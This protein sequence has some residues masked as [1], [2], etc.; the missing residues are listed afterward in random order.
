[1]Q[2]RCIAISSL[3]NSDFVHIVRRTQCV[4]HIPIHIKMIRSF[5][6][7]SEIKRSSLMNILR[8]L[9]FQY[10]DVNLSDDV[11][12]EDEPTDDVE[13]EVIY[14]THCLCDEQH[15]V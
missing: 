9:T 3:F 13:D 7:A 12:C 15:G 10:V 1:M 2:W 8:T 4:F 14:I 6:R 11:E 5:S